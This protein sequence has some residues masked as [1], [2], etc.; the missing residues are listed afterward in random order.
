[1]RRRRIARP[2][3][4]RPLHPP[5]SILQQL[6]QRLVGVYQLEALQLALMAEAGISL[7]HDRLDSRRRVRRPPCRG[8]GEA[9]RIELFELLLKLH[10]ALGEDVKRR[11]VG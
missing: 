2:A 3:R 10:L 11:A 6:H 9:R 4:P 5:F 1:M 8:V 7:P